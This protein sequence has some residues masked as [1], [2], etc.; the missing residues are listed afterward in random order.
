M[1]AVEINNTVSKHLGIFWVTN[2]FF[3]S[4]PVRIKKMDRFCGMF[5]AKAEWSFFPINVMLDM[6]I[7]YVRLTPRKRCS[8]IGGRSSKTSELFGPYT[9]GSW[10]T[11]Q[12]FLA[13]FT[14]L[15]AVLNT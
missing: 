7:N 5:T 9:I 14:L 11:F 6:I 10:A 3:E 12:N 1:F 15:P 13:C 8:S 2:P 4:F